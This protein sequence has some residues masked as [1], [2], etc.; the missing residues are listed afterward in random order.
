MA[1]MKANKLRESMMKK[2][3]SQLPATTTVKVT[4]KA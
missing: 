1:E 2:P 3:E 4:K